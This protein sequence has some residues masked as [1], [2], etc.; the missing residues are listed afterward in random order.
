MKR[1]KIMTHPRFKELYQ[2]WHG[3]M[4]RCYSPK[5]TNWHRYGGRGIRVCRRWHKFVN[6]AN[7]MPPRPNPWD[8]TWSIDRINN[9]R[10]YKLSN[11]RWATRSTQSNNRNF[12]TSDK[13]TEYQYNLQLMRKEDQ[14]VLRREKQRRKRLREKSRRHLLTPLPESSTIQSHETSGENIST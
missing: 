10:G 13:E 2:T 4:Y 7:D 1:Q 6:F 9:D 14:A 12:W 5:C 11:V 3:M 8:R